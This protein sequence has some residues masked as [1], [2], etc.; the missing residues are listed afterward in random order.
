MSLSVEMKNKYLVFFLVFSC[1]VLVVSFR[2]SFLTFAIK[3]SFK[4]IFPKSAVSLKSAHVTPFSFVV[5]ELEIQGA[6]GVPTDFNLKK[7]NIHLK[8]SFIRSFFDKFFGIDNGRLTLESA[9]YAGG[10][11]KGLSLLISRDDFFKSMD[12]LGTLKNASF[13][14]IKAKDIAWKVRLER[15]KVFIRQ[16]DIDIFG[17]HVQGSG[18]VLFDKTGWVLSLALVFQ[19]VDIADLMKALGAEERLKVTGLYTGPV[20]LVVSNARIKELIGDLD[21]RGKGEMIIKDTSLLGSNAIQKEAVNIV[22]ENLKNYYYDIGNIKVRN[23]AQDIKI[24]ISLK[25]QTGER[26]LRVLWHGSS[27]HDDKDGGK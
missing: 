2:N 27:I 25:G 20:R 18:D 16:I 21:S 13:Q 19:D 26:N 8:F 7:I 3:N 23:I 10:D 22:V 14:K 24:D 9:A 4:K 1:L 12:F 17:G 6:S 15:G 11:F 5:R